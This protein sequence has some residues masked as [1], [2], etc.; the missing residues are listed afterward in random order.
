MRNEYGSRLTLS[1]GDFLLLHR[2]KKKQLV[3]PCVADMARLFTYDSIELLDCVLTDDE[4]DP[5]FSP[6]MAL[7]RLECVVEYQNLCTDR[8]Y[9]SVEDF[10]LAHNYRPE[11]LSLLEKKLA[12]E[13]E[14]S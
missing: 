4:A 2:K 9:A 12:E 14:M 10:L 5:Q 1:G 11:D 6:S 8:P 13:Q 3:P 7:R